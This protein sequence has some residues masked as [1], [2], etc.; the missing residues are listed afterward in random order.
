MT[1]R[2]CGRLGAGASV[3]PALEFSEKPDAATAEAYLSSGEHVWN[4]GIVLFLAALLVK[5]LDA[6]PATRT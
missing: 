2:A 3:R 5:E 6:K 1:C 4:S